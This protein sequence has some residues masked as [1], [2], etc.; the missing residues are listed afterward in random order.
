MVLLAVFS[1]VVAGPRTNR[2]RQNTASAPKN[3]AAPS[4]W[5][6]LASENPSTHWLSVQPTGMSGIVGTQAT[7]SAPRD[8]VRA[9]T[10][11]LIHSPER[12]RYPS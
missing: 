1:S 8:A 2:T 12:G 9:V 6:V 10:R 11:S 7:A 3:T 4:Q 5:I